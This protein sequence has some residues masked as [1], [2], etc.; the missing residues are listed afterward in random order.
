RHDRVNHC[1]HLVP[2]EHDLIGH[3]VAPT[4]KKA[5]WPNTFRQFEWIFGPFTVV[6]PLPAADVTANFSLQNRRKEVRVFSLTDNPVTSDHCVML[7]RRYRG[8]ISPF[9]RGNS[10]FK[11]YVE[12]LADLPHALGRVRGEVFIVHL[13]HRS[14]PAL[15]YV[16]CLPQLLVSNQ[17]SVCKACLPE[18]PFAKSRSPNAFHHRI[19]IS[20]RKDER[21]SGN[22]SAMC[23]GQSYQCGVF[24]PQ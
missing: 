15:Q 6:A 16:A 24:S 4:F 3:P 11:G 19:L 7:A 14:P 9:E 23:S 18:K 5:W 21:A 13:V 1:D 20:P 10:G 8:P 12:K 17:R 22:F 2:T